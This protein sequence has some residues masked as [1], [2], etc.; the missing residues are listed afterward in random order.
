MKKLSK[1]EMKKVIGGVL[2][3]PDAGICGTDKE[4]YC[5]WDHGACEPQAYGS[6]PSGTESYCDNYCV[7]SDGTTYSPNT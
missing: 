1:E 6:C 3:P 4:A 7:R 2:A 5:Y